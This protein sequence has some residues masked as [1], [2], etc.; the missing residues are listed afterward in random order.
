MSKNHRAYHNSVLFTE[1]SDCYMSML[2][3]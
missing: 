1:A 3:W 2:C